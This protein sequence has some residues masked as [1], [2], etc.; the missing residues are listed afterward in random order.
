[1]SE[2]L[3]E[4]EEPEKSSYGTTVDVIYD[5]RRRRLVCRHAVF[6][7]C[8]NNFCRLNYDILDYKVDEEIRDRFKE[9]PE[10]VMKI[11]CWFEHRKNTEKLLREAGRR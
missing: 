1:M 2:P 7:T 4:E 9:H 8:C 11:D 10:D 5:K 6:Y 3:S